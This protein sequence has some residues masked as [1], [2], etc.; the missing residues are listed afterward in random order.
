MS[1]IEGKL[2]Q[3]MDYISYV[4]HFSFLICTFHTT[5]RSYRRPASVTPP[6]PAAVPGHNP[7]TSGLP[8]QEKASL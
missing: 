8:P 7:T 4:I 5:H 3:L 1:G 2:E 6:L